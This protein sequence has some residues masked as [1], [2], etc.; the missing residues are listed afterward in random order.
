MTYETK[1]NGILSGVPLWER[2]QFV[3][4]GGIYAPG[5]PGGGVTFGP[6]YRLPGQIG[7]GQCS[8]FPGGVL[9]C[10][11]APMGER[12]L[13]TGRGWPPEIGPAEESLLDQGCRPTNRRC[14]GT[15]KAPA[16]FWC[17]PG[18]SLMVG[19]PHAFGSTREV[20]IEEEPWYKK[21]SLLL[22]GAAFVAGWMLGS[23]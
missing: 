12:G 23:R 18:G 22:M 16:Q 11:Q 1:N 10:V 9:R 2:G 15:A 19:M 20:N 3:T 13:E 6:T 5:G 14:G 17:C 8:E 21:H 7:A 4:G